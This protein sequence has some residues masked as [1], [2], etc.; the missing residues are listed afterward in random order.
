MTIVGDDELHGRGGEIEPNVYDS[1]VCVIAVLDQLAE[2]N[3]RSPNQPFA[4]F[5][6]QGSVDG[7][8]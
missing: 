3:V 7:E 2:R 5:T 6:E 1:S 8:L 4:K